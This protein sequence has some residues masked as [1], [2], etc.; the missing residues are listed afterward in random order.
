MPADERD[1][2]G[3]RGQRFV[4][5]EHDYAVIAERFIDAIREAKADPNPARGV[6]R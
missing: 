5:S 6:R 4:R 2:L 1:E 3:R